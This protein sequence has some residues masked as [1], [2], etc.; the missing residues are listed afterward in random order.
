MGAFEK[1]RKKREKGKEGSYL[2][3]GEREKKER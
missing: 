1:E 3:E 2:R